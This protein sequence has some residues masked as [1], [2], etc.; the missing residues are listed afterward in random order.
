MTAA[1]TARWW[2]PLAD[3]RIECELCP[4]R[5]RLGRGQ[6][7]FCFVRRREGDRLLLDAWGRCSG[8]H[9]DPVEKKPLHHFL[10]GAAVLSFGTPGCN[11]ACRGCQNWT[12]SRSRSVDAGSVRAEPAAIAA[13]ARE[14]G[15]EAVA[16]TYNDPV[17]W[18]EYAIATAEACRAAG[19]KTI[20]VTAGYVEPAPRR[21]LCAVLDAAN[22]DLKC[23][24]EAGYCAHALCPPGGLAAVLDTLRWLRHRSPVWLEITTLVVPGFNDSEPELAALARWIAGELGPEVPLHL[25]AFHPDFRLRH[26]PPTPLA[27]LRRARAIARAAGLRHVYLGNLA[28]DEGRSTTCANCGELLIARRGYRLEEWRLRPDG[29]CPACGRRLAGVMPAAPPQAIVTSRQR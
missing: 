14:L 16:F 29:G 23:F 6:R 11:L 9:V 17:V 8:L 26:L 12:L 1:T 7:G 13:T 24:T 5:C 3:G 18:A 21:E 19:L 4:R 10:P 27:T 2:R 28:G 20:A 22:V 25:S 15:C